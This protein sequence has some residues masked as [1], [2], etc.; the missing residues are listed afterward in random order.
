MRTHTGEKPFGCTLCPE[1]FSR[2][3]NLTVHHRTH[4]GEKPYVCSVCSKGFSDCMILL[5]QRSQAYG[6]LLDAAAV[7]SSLALARHRECK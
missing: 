7:S 4:M 3:D 5:L 1:R 2:S 6:L